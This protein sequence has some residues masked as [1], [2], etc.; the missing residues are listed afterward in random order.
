V[1]NGYVAHDSDTLS[2]A[3][4]TI[5]N[6][7]FGK[8]LLS[9][10]FTPSPDLSTGNAEVVSKG[11]FYGYFSGAEYSVELA[12]ES[13][14]FSKLPVWQVLTDKQA[15]GDLSKLEF[16]FFFLTRYWHS[17]NL[18]RTTYLEPGGLFTLGGTDKEFVHR[19][20]HIEFYNLA[21]SDL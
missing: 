1:N 7:G 18:A 6:Q 11:A 20:Y 8:F 3:G 12:W 10:S 5:P 13:L 19:R 16:P 9:P 4:F 2:F 17:N 14:S 15:E 21:L